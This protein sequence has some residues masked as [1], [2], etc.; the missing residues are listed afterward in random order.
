[1][2]ETKT[3]TVRV[4]VDLKKRLDR[5]AKA[6]ER[7]RSWVATHALQHY[8]EA[9][10]WQLAEIEQGLRDEEEGR[11]IPHEKVDRWLRSWGSGRTLRPPTCK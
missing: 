10:E 1:M 3:F 9:Q 11:V 7:S 5:L 6:A 8:V 2:A 4:P